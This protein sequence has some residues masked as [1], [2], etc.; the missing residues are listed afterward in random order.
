MWQEQFLKGVAHGIPATYWRVIT[1][2][3]IH[4]SKALNDAKLLDIENINEA[5]QKGYDLS[6]AIITRA[7]KELTPDD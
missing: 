2:I 4:V 1:Q 5:H 3:V 7:L 6:Q